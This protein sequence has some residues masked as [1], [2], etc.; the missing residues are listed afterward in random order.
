[1]KNTALLALA[2]AVVPG[3]AA[4]EITVTG[5]ATLTYGKL[6]GASARVI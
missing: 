4:A 3:L 6:D 1:M 2:L 5:G